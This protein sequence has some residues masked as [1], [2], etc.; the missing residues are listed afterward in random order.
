MKQM[1]VRF[2]TTIG[3]PVVEETTEAEIAGISGIL[4][5]PDTAKIEGFFVR[6]PSFLRAEELFLS[7]SDIA[8]WGTR[9]RVRHADVLAPVEEHLRLMNLLQD[10]RTVMRQSIMTEGG[11]YLGVCRDIQFDTVSF[12]AEWLFPRTFLRW[13]RSIPVSSIVIVKPEAIVVRDAVLIP[14]PLS[15]ASVLKALDPLGSA[16]VP[17][18]M[19]AR[20]GNNTA[21]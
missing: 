3:L 2:S 12:Y 14:E 4:I 21:A 6:V 5:H 11:K 20:K 7:V 8:H 13:Q 16:P 17:S 19:C 10:G 9:V 15:G 1:H 18:T